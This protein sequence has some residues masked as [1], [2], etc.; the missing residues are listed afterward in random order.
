MKPQIFRIFGLIILSLLIFTEVLFLKD[1]FNNPKLITSDVI[2]LWPSPSP[3]P[4]LLPTPSPSPI[5]TNRLKIQRKPIEI[6]VS[7]SPGP[8]NEPWGVAKQISEHSYT[9]KIQQDSQMTTVPEL[10]EALNT[11]RKTKNVGPL[12]FDARLAEYA[13]TRADYFESMQK[14]DEHAGF[15]EYLSNDENF[16]KLGFGSMGEN[17]SWGYKMTGV[18]LIEWIYASDTGHDNNQLDPGWTSVGIG[19]SGTASELIFA[20][21]PL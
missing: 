5:R 7:P 9:M 1:Y 10:F 18:H 20:G 4:S 14:T 16:K 12:S 3:S 21:S 6:I 8:D 11:Y 17:S 2:S 13:Q 15:K 19:I